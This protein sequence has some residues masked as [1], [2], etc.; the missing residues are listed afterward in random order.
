MSTQSRVNINKQAKKSKIIE[1]M[2]SC[3]APRSS[4]SILKPQKESTL[5]KI[6][7]EKK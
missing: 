7:Y 4:D 5:L 3:I 2:K 6:I 1:T